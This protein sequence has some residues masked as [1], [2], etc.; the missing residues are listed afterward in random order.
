MNDTPRIRSA[1]V[2]KGDHFAGTLSKEQDSVVFRYDETYRRSGHPPVA[3]TLPFAAGESRTVA[4][5]VP[6]FFAGLLPEGRRLVALQRSVKSSKDDEFAQLVAIGRDCIGDVRVVAAGEVP[7][8]VDDEPTFGHAENVSFSEIF[9][10]SLENGRVAADRSIPGVQDK[11]SDAMLSLPVRTAGLASILKLTP[12]AYPRL[13]ENEAFFLDMARAGGLRVPPFSV[14]HDR[15]GMP[16]LVVERFDRRLERKRLVRVAQ[17][18]AVQVAGR[19]P[20]AK[21]DMSTRE[22]FD[23]VLRVATAKPVAAV[24]LLRQFAFAY[25]IGNGDLHAKNVSVYNEPAGLWSVTPAYDLVSTLPYGDD[26]LALE[27]DG[28]DRNLTG[29]ILVRFAARFGLSEKVAR[30]TIVD[31]AERIEPLVDSVGDIGFDDRTTTQLQTAIT[32]RIADLRTQGA[33]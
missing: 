12:P 26:R 5:A 7:P 21:Y 3:T 17:E 18:D 14:V 33:L 27:L 15:T 28:R 31:L 10:R 20:A 16:G 19:W 22:V 24:A 4:G 11:I 2:Y 9:D 29:T 30:N 8:E 6:P 25:A 1:D 13:V 23:A 32:T